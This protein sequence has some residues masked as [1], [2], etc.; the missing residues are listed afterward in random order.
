LTEKEEWLTASFKI[1]P[2]S[3]QGQFIF[4]PPGHPIDLFLSPQLGYLP[5][6]SLVQLRQDHLFSGVGRDL[7]HSR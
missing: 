4:R 5:T 3:E 6:E 1:F 7:E 2:C